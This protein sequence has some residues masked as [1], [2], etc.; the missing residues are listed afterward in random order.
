MYRVTVLRRKR[1]EFAISRYVGG[2]GAHGASLLDGGVLTICNAGA[3]ATGGHGALGMVSAIA[4]G[5]AIRVYAPAGYL[6]GARLT[7]T[8]CAADNIPYTLIADGMS[9][10]RSW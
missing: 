5:R 9:G 2:S 1:G 7:A 8:E 4:D 3:L 10:L 6:Q